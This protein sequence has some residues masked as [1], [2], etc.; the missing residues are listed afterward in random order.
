MIDKL[1]NVSRRSV[2]K[3][4]TATAAVAASNTL[5]A[6]MIWAQNIRDI[7][8]RQFGTGVSNLNEVAEQVRADL[9]F[10][11]EMTALDTDA[12]TNRVAT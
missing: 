11:L 12:V 7:T 10:T 8:L 2:L 1:T 3:G 4:A 5:G 6:P 9:G